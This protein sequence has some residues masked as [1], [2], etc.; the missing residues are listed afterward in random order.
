MLQEP[1]DLQ[2]KVRRPYVVFEDLSGTEHGSLQ[3][4][5]RFFIDTLLK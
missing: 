3:D 4:D 5:D 2:E 1:E